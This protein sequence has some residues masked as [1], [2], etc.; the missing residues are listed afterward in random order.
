LELKKNEIINFDLIDTKKLIEL[1]EIIA[2]RADDSM[3]FEITRDGLKYTPFMQ[4]LIIHL[5]ANNTSYTRL[6]AELK[7]AGHKSVKALK[8]D[9]DFYNDLTDIRN[10]LLEFKADLLETAH[11]DIDDAA[12]CQIFS[13]NLKFLLAR[14]LP[15]IYGEQATLNVNYVNLKESLQEADRRVIDLKNAV[16]HKDD[17]DIFD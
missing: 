10:R 16:T 8:N 5:V 11:E 1:K 15:K 6:L 12:R 3:V 4:A 13:T 2:N 14:R 7:I 17:D 9:I